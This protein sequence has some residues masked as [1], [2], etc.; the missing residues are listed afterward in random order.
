MN[1]TDIE[2][3]AQKNGAENDPFF[4]GNGEYKKPDAPKKKFS[5]PLWARIAIY[6]AVCAALCAGSFFIGKKVGIKAERL[7]Q[8]LAEKA[9]TKNNLLFT[10]GSELAFFLLPM[11]NKDRK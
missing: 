5:L 8:E 3:A 10:F 11:P 6:A 7:A 1:N 9:N 4:G 2:N